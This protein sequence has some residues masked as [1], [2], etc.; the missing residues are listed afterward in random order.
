MW[1]LSVWSE[2]K[3]RKFHIIAVDIQPTGMAM[4]AAISQSQIAF[5]VTTTRAILACVGGVH[6]LEAPTSIFYFV[7]DERKKLKLTTNTQR[8]VKPS[9][10]FSCWINAVFEGFAHE[11][12]SPLRNGENHKRPVFMGVLL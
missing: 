11:K 10:L 7:G 4:I 6:F 12:I 2:A 3:Y 8:L 1:T 9:F 5:P